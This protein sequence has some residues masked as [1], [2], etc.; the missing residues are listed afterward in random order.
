MDYEMSEEDYG[1]M[2][3]AMRP[4]PLIA[5]HCGSAPS[6]QERANAAWKRL[7]DKMGFDHMTAGPNGKGERCFAAT[8]KTGE[9]K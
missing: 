3:E 7:G 2:L 8:P 5:L 6:Q 4:L 9:P 1:K